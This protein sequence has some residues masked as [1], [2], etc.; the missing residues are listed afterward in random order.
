M[1][2]AIMNGSLGYRDK[3]GKWACL[4]YWVTYFENKPYIIELSVNLPEFNGMMMEITFTQ[5]LELMLA[6][7]AA[8]QYKRDPTLTLRHF[9]KKFLPFRPSIPTP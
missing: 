1:E 4:A 6:V 9:C 7:E 8:Q 5:L 2:K 3:Q